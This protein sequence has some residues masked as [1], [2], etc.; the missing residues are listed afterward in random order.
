MNKFIEKYWF[1]PNQWIDNTSCMSI[2]FVIFISGIVGALTTIRSPVQFVILLFIFIATLC[3]RGAYFYYLGQKEEDQEINESLDRIDEYLDRNKDLI[4]W[5][6]SVKI[7]IVFDDS[8]W[9]I[10]RNDSR[11]DS[12]FIS[13]VEIARDDSLGSALDKAKESLK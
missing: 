4:N 9:A 2:V 5:I 13:P 12:G 6:S 1:K 10:F 3:Y 11:A 8:Q 7:S